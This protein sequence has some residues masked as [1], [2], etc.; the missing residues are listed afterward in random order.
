MA[1]SDKLRS[2]VVQHVKPLLSDEGWAKLRGLD[3]TSRT[4]DVDRMRVQRDEARARAV[5]AEAINQAPD[6]TTRRTE[7]SDAADL[8]S[9][10]GK[11]RTDK[12]SHQHRYT[13]HYARHIGYLRNEPFTLLEVGIGGYA[14]EL[15]GGA[16]LRM[17]KEFF[18]RATI[19][20]LDIEDKK[21]VDEDRI[22]S[23][24]GSQ[25]DPAIL[26][27]ILADHP[28]IRVIIDDG[29]HVNEHVVETFRLLFPRLHPQGHY[30]IEDTQT[31]YWPRYGGSPD[32]LATHTS[33]ALGKR[34]ADDINFQ[35]YTDAHHEPTYD[36]ANVVGVHFYHNLIFVDKGSND[37]P[38]TSFPHN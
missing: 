35:E 18:P 33:M 25:V 8:R 23:Y 1:F 20:G 4:R 14:R 17:W 5:K 27:R 6:H 13:P 26:D 11:Y 19:V 38:R 31:A 7:A 15:D 36:Q 29:S 30:V 32:L 9:L 10:A 21:F 37:E 2:G 34:L 16:S 3:P 24:Q 12:W 22:I 28:D